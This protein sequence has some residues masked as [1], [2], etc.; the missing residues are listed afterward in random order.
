MQLLPGRDLKRAI[1][2]HCANAHPHICDYLVA[3]HGCDD[4]CRLAQ[5]SGTK[6]KLAHLRDLLL[7]FAY[8]LKNLRRIR[9]AEVIIALGPMAPNIAMLLK[10]GLLPSCRKVFWFGLFVHDPRWLQLLRPAFRFL[11]SPKIQYV[12]FS[13]FEKTLY[14]ASGLL[15]A[16]RLFYV[17]YGDLSRLDDLPSTG[18][19]VTGRQDEDY[20]FSGG[21]SN[22]DYA[23]LIEIFRALPYK[24]VI[25]CSILNTEVT[26]AT[27]PPN[28]RVFRDLG[29]SEF[30][31]YL[32]A[33]KA[34]LIPIAHDSGAAGQ[35]VLLRCMRNRKVIIATDTGIVREYVT[36]GISAILV[37]NNQG[38][39]AE[40]V[41]AVAEA[42]DETYSKYAEAAYDRYRSEF[43][44]LAT[45][46]KLDEMV[47]LAMT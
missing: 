11:D 40:A 7:D 15:P 25:V 18:R 12:L 39:M 22:R 6:S 9:N 24:L 16:D 17:P 3:N 8:A 37:A 30:D 47:R 23:S 5:D 1:V 2:R 21:Y 27:L 36:D 4:I 31:G 13:T 44:G 45:A 10:L 35:S 28:V 38:A 26:A 32:R 41:C 14:T 43:S 19:Q 34:C 33:S 29:S 42:R 46:R 20:F